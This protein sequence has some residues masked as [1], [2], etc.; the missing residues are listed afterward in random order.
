[1]FY[2]Y[3]T[4]SGMFKY[5]YKVKG[6]VILVQVVEALRVARGRGYHI[7]RHRLTDGDKVVSPT[8]RPLFTAQEDSWYSFLLE[9]ESIPVPRCGWKD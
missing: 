3:I 5:Q 7:F 8:R 9:A 6:K 4:L 1:M 2:F